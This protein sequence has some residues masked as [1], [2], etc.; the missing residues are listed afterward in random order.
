MKNNIHI[1]KSFTHKH[2]LVLSGILFMGMLFL[3]SFAA[4]NID[5]LIHNKYAKEVTNW[6]VTLGEDQSCLDTPKTNL[7]YYGQ[8]IDN[9]AAF[10]NR[11]FS[12]E[13]EYTTRHFIGAAFAFMLLLTIGYTAKEIS[14]SYFAGAIALLLAFIS[15]RLMGHAYGNLKDIPFAFGYAFSILFMI[16]L[17]KQLPSP[18]WK[19]I[20]CLALG[21]A[22]TNSVRIGGLVLFAYFGLFFIVWLIMN[23]QDYQDI[24]S[25]LKFW[26]GI[27]LKALVL[28]L[29]GYFLAF[30]LWPYA[31]ANPLKNPLESLSVMEHYKISI[32]QIF[33]GQ[34]YWST[35]LPWYYLPKWLLISIPEIVW[36]GA[37]AAIVFVLLALSKIDFRKHLNYGIV[38]FTF[39]FP[40]IYVILIHSNLYSGWRQMYFIYA[41]L[42]VISAL[43]I[44]LL[45]LK[46][47][48]LVLYGCII[49][50]IFLAGLP[51]VHSCEVFPS[52]YIYFNSFVGGN[53]NAWSNYEYDYYWHEMKDAAKWLEKNADR[54]EKPVAIASNFNV[55]PYLDAEKF[56]HQYVH[57]YDK[58]STKWD[59]AILGVN[60][61]H[62]YQLKNNTWQQANV[63]KTF[64]H[65]GNPT[66]III[67]GQDRNAI[68][69]F[70]SLKNQ[71]FEKAVESLSMA[72]KSDPNDI[73]LRVHL[74]EAYLALGQLKE[75]DE[76]VFEGQKIHP[77][78]ES[79][80]LLT[81][82]KYIRQEMYAEGLNEL[83]S[84][85]EI[86]PRYFSVIPYLVTC[87]EQ[88]GEFSK[89]EEIK[90]KYNIN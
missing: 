46:L 58:I 67:K 43:G 35:N 56:T 55:I 86:N 18:Q 30:V 82:K 54:D 63:L 37:L 4:I 71:E 27:A 1:D 44:R 89:A 6:Y 51:V 40:L 33:E 90:K 41:P 31:L 21:I 64:Y 12:I 70:Y 57:F 39:L 5:E 80:K 60:Y 34:V 3:A 15:P 16:K 50:L 68:E 85:V 11:S 47:K 59:Y 20:L 32:K 24:L 87:Y 73:N 36:I 17:L 25:Q 81:A 74:G 14:G 23:Y 42:V 61:V 72:L 77:Y 76:L 38:V 49:V 45:L 88:T 28:A 62:P 22:F 13:N 52:D 10:V 29:V 79:L 65:K 69:G 83:K 48:G 2:F 19:T 75:L 53:K 26:K 84:I 7:K 66:V 78:Y 9:L 8:S